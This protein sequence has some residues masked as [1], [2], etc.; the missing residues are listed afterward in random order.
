MFKYKKEL[1]QSM[2]KDNTQKN[3]KPQVTQEELDE[4]KGLVESFKD[5]LIEKFKDYVLTVS[6]LPPG[7]DK[8]KINVL[9]L[10]DD[11]ESE[12][13]TQKELRKK[14]ESAVQTKAENV[15]ERLSPDVRLISDVWQDYYDGNTEET[16]HIV[17]SAPVYDSGMLSALKVSNVH[18]SMVL[19]RFEKYIVSYVLA[20]SLVQGKATPKSDIDVFIVIDDTD[21]KKMS[22]AELKDKLRAIIVGM[23]SEASQAVG[24]ENKL[25]IQVYILTDF[26]DMIKQANPII[27]TFLRDG[28]PLY[29][30]G[31]FMAWKQLLK[32]GRIK[33]SPEAIDM[34]MNTGSQMMKKVNKK[35]KD[36]AM[37]DF[38][39]ATIT[40]SQAAIMLYGLPPPTPKET[41]NVVK[42]IFVDK[43][44]F[45]DI[46]D[47]ETIKEVLKMRK[48][49]E[50]GEKQTVKGKDIDHLVDI[51]QS[52]LK[53]SQSLFDE[54][55]ELKNEDR[56]TDMIEDVESSVNVALTTE[57]EDVDS[58][59]SLEEAVQS[60]LVTPGKVPA[61]IVRDIKEIREAN[62]QYKDNSLPKAEINNVVRK[63]R[64]VTQ[65]LLEHAQRNKAQD[66]DS[67][68]LRITFGDSHGE[69][70][71]LGDGG[72]LTTYHG[73]TY[74][75][76]LFHSHSDGSIN[77]IE[78]ISE[79]EAEEYVENEELTRREVNKVFIE[80]LEAYLDTAVSLHL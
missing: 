79:E 36:I 52:F 54:I 10:I 25:N 71:F 75:N 68:K 16:Q 51:T 74:E 1:L 28:V 49:L 27:F 34:F 19:E 35:L 32:M 72:L 21:V 24:V 17:Q 22:R 62:E 20:G 57:D 80:D 45:L 77:T 29:D 4:I 53:K 76:H 41:P 73:E 64:Q 50:H 38:F 3:S 31:I 23:A 60:V 43:E 78:E 12:K 69:I 67:Y 6:L 7:E 46:E 58:Y 47:V 44:D 8:Q 66:K 13:L 9:V 11:A 2:N 42:E 40:T 55:Q 70:L 48:D 63:G 33:P 26:W 65:A 18:K 56:F 39:W 5:N 37:E 61:R 14:L 30:R 15:S 59:N